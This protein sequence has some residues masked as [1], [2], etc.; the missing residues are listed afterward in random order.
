MIPSDSK[1]WLITGASS[2]LGLALTRR[3]L[4]RGDRVIAT[5]RTLEGGQFADTV[6]SEFDDRSTGDGCDAARE[7]LR[8]LPLDVGAPFAEVQRQADEAIALWGRIDVLVNNAGTVGREF[9]PSEE[10]GLDGMRDPFEVNFFGVVKVTNAF[11]PHM[12]SRRDGTIVILGSRSVYFNEFP[13]IAAYAASKAA[14][15]SY[16]ETLA[17]ELAPL[18]IRVL[19]VVPGTFNAGVIPPYTETLPGYESTHDV[20]DAAMKAREASKKG[21]PAR[22]MDAVVDVVRGEG[23]AASLAHAGKW[24]RWLVLGEDAF[25]HVRKRLQNMADTLGEWEAVGSDV[26]YY[27]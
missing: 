1:T 10:L 14:V 5:A 17:V 26:Y 8:L 23:R 3:V 24:P 25:A 2:G 6:L 4:N 12:R 18:N 11:L 22:G 15:H 19:L 21:D 16:S 20:M 27:R 13:G 7:R 9:G